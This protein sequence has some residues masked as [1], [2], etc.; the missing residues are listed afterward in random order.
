MSVSDRNRRLLIRPRKIFVFDFLFFLV[1]LF[2]SVLI[3]GLGM[4][5]KL[6]T[7]WWASGLEVVRITP[8]ATEC[9]TSTPSLKLTRRWCR[10]LG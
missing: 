4:M 2:S 7:G 1:I 5:K 3:M 8:V 9:F 6:T 10:V